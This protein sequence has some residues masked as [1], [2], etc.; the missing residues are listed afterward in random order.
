MPAF[1]NSIT[2]KPEKESQ[3]THIP[4]GLFFRYNAANKKI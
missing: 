2:A 1:I 4:A 3:W